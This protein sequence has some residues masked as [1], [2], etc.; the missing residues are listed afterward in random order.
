MPDVHPR[1]KAGAALVLATAAFFPCT[2]LAAWARKSE[3]PG[4]A[5][6]LA[7]LVAPGD[8]A[9][10]SPVTMA[11]HIRCAGDGRQHAPA[12]PDPKQG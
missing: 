2:D 11:K 4:I 8:L 5:D 3:A 12:P 9:A 7:G 6:C 1:L 10:C